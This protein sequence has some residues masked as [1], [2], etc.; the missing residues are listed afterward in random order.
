ML[1]CYKIPRAARG[2]GTSA[3][4]GSLFLSHLL[5]IVSLTKARGLAIPRALWEEWLQ[6]ARVDRGHIHN[7]S[8][9]EVFHEV[10]DQLLFVF[11]SH[12]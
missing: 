6:G 7:Q 8:T 10:S 11:D 5:A 12:L 2:Q 1:T 3:L 4:Q 9:K